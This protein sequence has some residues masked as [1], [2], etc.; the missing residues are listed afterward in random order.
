MYRLENNEDNEQQKHTFCNI[1]VDKR[2]RAIETVHGIEGGEADG[3]RNIQMGK[4]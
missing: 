3:E 1:V 4:K 2:H